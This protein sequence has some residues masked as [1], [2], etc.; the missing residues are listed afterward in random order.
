MF[1]FLMLIKEMRWRGE[2]KISLYDI[3]MER[4]PLDFIRVVKNREY[5]LEVAEACFGPGE[6]PKVKLQCKKY[7]PNLV[8]NYSH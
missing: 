5:S 1:F 7:Q 4:L 6:T 3:G 8:V 2:F